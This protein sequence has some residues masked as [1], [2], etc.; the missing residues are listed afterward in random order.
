MEYRP[1]IS[2]LFQLTGYQPP[3][4]QG[5]PNRLDTSAI[6]LDGSD[7]TPTQFFGDGEL[8]KGSRRPGKNNL[9]PI[10]PNSAPCRHVRISSDCPPGNWKDPKFSPPLNRLGSAFSATSRHRPE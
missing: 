4:I 10:R 1:K 8:S 5:S 2:R 7:T 9:P 3:A 6:H